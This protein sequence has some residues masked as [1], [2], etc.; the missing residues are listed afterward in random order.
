MRT[1]PFCPLSELKQP[2]SPF[3]YPLRVIQPEYT[4]PT[5]HIQLSKISEQVALFK[6]ALPTVTPHY[7]VKANPLPQVLKHLSN[8]G[9]NF[10]IASLTELS[11]MKQLKV[12]G[13]RIIFSHPIKTPASIVKAFEYGINWFAFDNKEELEKL[14]Q[15]APNKQYELRIS[16][17]GKGSV[18]PLTKKFGVDIQSA[19]ELIN[20]AH[21]NKIKISGLTFH[22]GSQCTDAKSWLTALQDCNTV[23]KHMLDKNMPIE[24][25]NIGGGFPCDTQDLIYEDQGLICEDQ[26]KPHNFIDFMQPVREYLNKLKANLASL[27]KI[28]LDICAEPG[29]F[30]LASSGV[31][32][33]QIISTT[34][35]QSQP[36]AYLDCGYY[37]GLMELSE[38]FGYTLTS[39]RNGKQVPWI[40]AGPTCDSIDCFEP[41]YDL[42]NDCQAGDVLTIKNMGAYANACVTQFNGFEGPTVFVTD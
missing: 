32:T 3:S 16:T 17:N 14:N 4:G 7:A 41:M 1:L 35:K 9:V 23:I 11:L 10:E 42:P 27:D 13:E 15:L 25:L 20:H 24:M 36:W 38:N 29:R 2:L 18:W 31:L 22:V 5:L 33:C 8:L 26:D 30:L 39:Q 34:V 28:D 37:N 12:D 19:I 6:L 21:E 40:I